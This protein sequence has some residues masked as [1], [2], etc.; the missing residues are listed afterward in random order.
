[1]NSSE[2]L[3]SEVDNLVGIAEGLIQMASN[4]GSDL[5]PGAV[6]DSTMM[7]ARSGQLLRRIYSDK[8]QPVQMFNNLIDNYNFS[9]MHSNYYGHLAQLRGILEATKYEIENGLL[10]SI[11][12][13][14]QASIFVDFLEMGEYLLDEGYK[15]AAA[16]LIGGVL[17]DT[18]RKVAEMRTVPTVSGKGKPLTIEP[19]N[20]ALA[21]DGA[22]DQLI[23]KQ[24]TSWGDL[25]NKAAHGHYDEYDDGQVRM[26]LLFVQGFLGDILR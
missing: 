18:L 17:E 22:Y 21:K 11:Q 14:I 1:M 26:M 4:A 13:L 3:I 20:L 6:A 12:G 24:I 10:D 8:S 2:S 9:T 5:G 23:R 7:V 16:V 19:L 25:R 15:D